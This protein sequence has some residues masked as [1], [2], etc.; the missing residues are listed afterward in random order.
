[1]SE[2]IH[3]NM[4]RVTEEGEQE[5]TGWLYSP[6]ETVFAL[7]EKTPQWW[8]WRTHKLAYGVVLGMFNPPRQVQWAS[9]EQYASIET[10]TMTMQSLFEGETL[11]DGEDY[12]L[13]ISKLLPSNEQNEKDEMRRALQT[14]RDSSRRDRQIE[15]RRQLIA[16]YP[17]ETD[18]AGRSLTFNGRPELKMLLCNLKRTTC[19]FPTLPS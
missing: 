8:D 5:I 7:M 16:L 9:Q 13:M 6:Q 15:V 3:V 11:H 12:F 2:R 17:L 18:N 4:W 1:M 14:Q 19:G 10:G